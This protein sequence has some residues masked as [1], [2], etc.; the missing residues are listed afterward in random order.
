MK[1]NGVI[2][3]RFSKNSPFKNCLR[4]TVPTLGGV[5]YVCELL[6]KKEILAFELDNVLFDTQNSYNKALQLVW[7]YFTN[8]EITYDEIYETKKLNALNCDIETLKFLFEKE[9]LY[10]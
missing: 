6:N 5:K 2:T 7:Q 3:K 4:I 10:I 9:E 8:K 1:N